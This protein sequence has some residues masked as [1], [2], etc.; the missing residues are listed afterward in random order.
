MLDSL[1]DD[2]L[3]SFL[4]SRS[5]LTNAQL[6]T[7]MISST[8]NGELQ[9]KAAMRDGG[10][11]SEGS[12]LRTL[13]QGQINIERCLYT[14]FLL[15]YL[16]LVENK[17]LERLL[18]VST[19]ISKVKDSSPEPEAI[20]RLFTVLEGVAEGFSRRKKKAYSVI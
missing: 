15:N 13:H 10:K 16:G 5:S 19:L 1:K 17:D 8:A 9:A 14:M 11:V 20:E 12:F 4:L 2:A 18:G 7:I 6:D 3:L